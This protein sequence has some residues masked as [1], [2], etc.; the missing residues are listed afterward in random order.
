L[1]KFIE[2]NL[3]KYRVLFRQKLPQ[4][5]LE[6]LDG[7]AISL[8]QNQVEPSGHEVVGKT[9]ARFVAGAIDHRIGLL[10]VAAKSRSV[11]WLDIGKVALVLVGNW[12]EVLAS[13]EKAAKPGEN[14]VFQVTQLSGK[15]N[16]ARNTSDPD[17]HVGELGHD[18]LVLEA[19]S[20]PGK[21]DGKL[22]KGGGLEHG[23]VKS[24]IDGG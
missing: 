21:R 17:E 20:H 16:G 7:V 14:V 18:D 9:L 24:L 3:D 10:R 8:N 11:T 15:M 4:L 22:R 2:H 6:E 23:S 5:V 12:L 13:V 19:E 1:V